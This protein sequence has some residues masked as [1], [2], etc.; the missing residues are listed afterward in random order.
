VKKPLASLLISAAAVAALAVPAGAAVPTKQATQTVPCNDGSGKSAQVWNTAGHLAA[1]NPCR[2]WLLMGYG[3]STYASGADSN[4][5]ALAP[6]A[7]F[8]WGRPRAVRVD[9][10]RPDDLPCSSTTVWQV[11]YSYKD[12]RSWD[13]C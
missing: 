12:V 2:M 7:H 13:G 8:N 3:S 1:T 6:G 11:V 4:G 10:A 5:Y 9:Y